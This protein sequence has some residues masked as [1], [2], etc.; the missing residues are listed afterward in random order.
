MIDGKVLRFHSIQD[1]RG[2]P[3]PRQP[4]ATFHRRGPL[5]AARGSK[6][7]GFLAEGHAW[8]FFAR[9]WFGCAYQPRTSRHGI[10]SPAWAWEPWSRG[11]PSKF[12]NT[13]CRWP[14]YSPAPAGTADDDA[15]DSARYSAHDRLKKRRLTKGLRRARRFWWF[16]CNRLTSDLRDA[17]TNEFNILERC[18]QLWTF[19]QG[20]H[21]AWDDSLVPFGAAAIACALNRTG[22]HMFIGDNAFFCCSLKAVNTSVSMGDFATSTTGMVLFSLTQGFHRKCFC[23]ACAKLS[24]SW[25]ASFDGWALAP[26][27]TE[28]VILWALASDLAR[29]CTPSLFLE[30]CEKASVFNQKAWGC[31]WSFGE[32]LDEEAF[33]DEAQPDLADAGGHQD[34][35]WTVALVEIMPALAWRHDAWQA[36]LLDCWM[37][38]NSTIVRQVCS[39]YIYI[40][41]D[42]C[43]KYM[44]QAKNGQHNTLQNLRETIATY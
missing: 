30:A 22:S 38:R 44:I 2:V 14:S 1:A 24:L 18:E 34:N 8:G 28:E 32:R 21:A 25:K 40:Y 19:V 9:R 20:G 12:G 27:R 10:G 36:D 16:D 37:V 7:A 15:G 39:I 5:H 26:P 29:F 17:T 31:L 11:R 43:V 13:A 6:H 42:T 33:G 4:N 35:A 23:S 41:M 3:P